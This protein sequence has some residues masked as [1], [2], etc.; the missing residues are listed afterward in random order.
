[1]SVI[2]KE[3]KQ[4]NQENINEGIFS[5]YQQKNNNN[6]P[7][8]EEIN[9]DSFDFNINPFNKDNDEIKQDKYELN[10]NELLF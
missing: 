9:F 3:E 4:I 8:K 6:Q 7:E 2:R 10:S 5:I 1:M